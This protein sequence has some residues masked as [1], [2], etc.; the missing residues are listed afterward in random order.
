MKTQ[1]FI[2]WSGTQS[3]VFAEV[4]RRML[5]AVLQNVEHRAEYESQW[6]AVA[7]MAVKIGCT[8]EALHIWMRRQKRDTWR[9]K[10]FE[11]PE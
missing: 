1:V 11:V 6:A 3:K 5:P 2:S 9:W 10:S 7:A 4:L 8:A